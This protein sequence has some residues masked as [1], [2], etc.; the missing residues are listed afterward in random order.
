[1]PRTENRPH[2]SL[3][4]RSTAFSKSSG[5]EFVGWNIRCATRRTLF[6]VRSKVSAAMAV[7]SFFTDASQPI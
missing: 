7:L 6:D 5:S 2:S 4:V 3:S 1:M